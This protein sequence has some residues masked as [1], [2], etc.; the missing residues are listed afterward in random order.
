MLTKITSQRLLSLIFALTLTC[1]CAKSQNLLSMPND[2]DILLPDSVS[3]INTPDSVVNDTVMVFDALPKI[4]SLP[5]V[6]TNYR[7]MDQWDPFAPELTGDANMEWIER[8]QSV[9][10][11]TARMLQNFMVNH[12]E[13]VHKNI[14]FM[15]LPPKKYY[16]TVNPSDHS[17]EIREVVIDAP[18]KIEV[19]VDKKHWL[20]NFT[21]SLQF[22]QA[23]IS[24]NWYQG[25]N[26]NL[27]V[28]ANIVYNV[29]LNPAYHP[30]LLFESTMQ[31]KL[32]INS[33]PDDTI[34]SYSISEDL[35]QLNATFGIKAVN[36]WYYSLTGQFK[37]QLFTSYASNTNNM[38]SS[39]LAPAEL[40][41]GLGMTYSYAS[42]NKKVTL[43]ASISPLSYNMKMCIKPD[44]ELSH[45]TFGIKPDRTCNINI[46]SSAE[47]K[48]AWKIMDN[49]TYSTRLFLFTDYD[50]FEADWE[51]TLSMSINKYLATQIYVHVRYDTTTPDIPDS[52]WK[53]LQLKEILSFGISYKFSTL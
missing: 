11:R 25:G 32:G 27:N 28:I 46:G 21:A 3:L 6:Y 15:E 35:L 16:G 1:F 23:Y 7:I 40:N 2:N 38:T 18:E 22:S 5:P 43:D 12:P 9:E 31:Y 41:L 26:N 47:V 19:E 39:F 52:N 24:P 42:P 20:K 48:F 51:N 13:L 10:N 29:K 30:N 36:H 33:A 45:A 37:T 53:K 17:I 4:I 49:I 50:Q 14:A 44:R 8:S 34:R